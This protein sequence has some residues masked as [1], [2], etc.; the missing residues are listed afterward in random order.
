MASIRKVGFHAL[1]STVLGRLLQSAGFVN[2]F[3]FVL[4]ADHSMDNRAVGVQEEHRRI[5][6]DA[7]FA[8]QFGTLALFG[9]YLVVYG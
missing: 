5:G 2:Q 4:R 8:F 7:V 3:L 9:V 1:H 6:I